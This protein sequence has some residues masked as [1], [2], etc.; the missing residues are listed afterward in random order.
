VGAWHCSKEGDKTQQAILFS[1][2]Q[3]QFSP[4]HA[5]TQLAVPKKNVNAP[6]RKSFKVLKIFENI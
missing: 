1:L 2:L 4:L 5:T 6:D 3:K